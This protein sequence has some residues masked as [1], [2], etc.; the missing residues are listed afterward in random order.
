VLIQ[1]YWRSIYRNYDPKVM[2]AD[3]H[4]TFEHHQYKWWIN[5]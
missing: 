1:P 2:G 4:A 5:A 3:M